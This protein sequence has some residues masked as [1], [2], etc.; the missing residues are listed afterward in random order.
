MNTLNTPARTTHPATLLIVAGALAISIG[1]VGLGASPAAAALDGSCRSSD[2]GSVG[3]VDHPADPEAIV[4][5]MSVGGGFVP[6]EYAFMENPTF[7]LYG[8]D[9]AVYR[10][11]S[12]AADAPFGGPLNAYECSLLTSEQVDELLTLALDDAGLR[13]AEMAYP[14]PFIADVPSTTFSIDAD[15]VQKR[16]VVQGLGFDEGAPDPEARAAFLALADILADYQDQVDSSQLYEVPI[17]A[18]ILGDAWPE[19]EGTP[20]AWPWDEVS[21]ADIGDGFDP[22]GRLT[23]EQVALVA[24]VPNGGQAFILLETPTGDRVSLTISPILPPA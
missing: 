22:S 10:P 17:Y 19:L 21:P 24:A 9:I 15:G 23:S 18:A 12:G 5:Q 16:V 1:A 4:L 7:T 6:F 8:N 3:A 13:D 2:P 14:N 11:G 20:V